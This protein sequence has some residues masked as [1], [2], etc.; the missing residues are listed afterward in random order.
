MMDA[1]PIIS[2]PNDFTTSSTSK[3]DLPVVTTSSTMMTLSPL[4]SST[5]FSTSFGYLLFL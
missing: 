1:Y 2:E 5:L 3:V 4:L